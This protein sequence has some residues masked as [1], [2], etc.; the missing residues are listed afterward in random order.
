[1]RHAHAL[2]GGKRRQAGMIQIAHILC[3]V[4][5]SEFSQRAVRHAVTMAGSY[6]ARLTVLHVLETVRTVDVPP[7]ALTA[8]DR[9]HLVKQMQQLVGEAPSG[10]AMEFLVREAHDVRREIL[11]QIDSLQAD[12]VVIGSHGRTGFE[13]LLLGS[14][15]EHVLRK[16]PCPVLVVPRGAPGQLD[17]VHFARVLCP[18]DFSGGSLAALTYASSIARE[19]RAHLT[20][21]HVIELPPELREH[22]PEVTDLDIDELHAAARA[23]AIRRLRDLVT[24]SATGGRA[25]DTLVR[26]GA[27]YRHILTIAAEQRSDLI[28]MGVQ[29]RSAVDLLVFG[30][31]T[32]RVM[33]AATCPVLTVR[34]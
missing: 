4:D 19:T 20:V 31:N 24:A 21:L 6:R 11:D 26:E 34:G 25:V 30:S 5:F 9:E 13:K 33:R 17:R 14:V 7:V 27:A 12:L 32:A 15:A 8:A 18:V 10:V 16:A 29:G 1:M 2:P 3:P 28:V 23:A 22:Y